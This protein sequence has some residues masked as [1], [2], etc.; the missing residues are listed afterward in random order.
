MTLIVGPKILVTSLEFLNV[1]EFIKLDD[2]SFNPF[3]VIIWNDNIPTE[4]TYRCTAFSVHWAWV[5]MKLLRVQQDFDI[6][7]M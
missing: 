3:S 7:G 2:P 4:E 6:K 5:T 1:V